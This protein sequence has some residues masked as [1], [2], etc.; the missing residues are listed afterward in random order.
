MCQTTARDR[1]FLQVAAQVTHRLATIGREQIFQGPGFETCGPARADYCY[2]RA[3]CRRAEMRLSPA[4]N[5]AA[6][7]AL[8]TSPLVL[9]DPS[10]LCRCASI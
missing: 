9:N 6:C 2:L 10:A 1:R 8:V 4:P 5:P 3:A 7:R